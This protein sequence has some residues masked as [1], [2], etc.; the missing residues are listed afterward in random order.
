MDAWLAGAKDG[1]VRTRSGDR[2]KPSV[3][4]SHETSMRLRVLDELGALKLSDVTRP[5]LQ[6]VADRMLA[7]GLDPSTIRNALMPLRT[8]FRAPFLAA[9]SPSTDGGS[10]A[11]AVRGKRDRIASPAEAVA[12]L[13]A[14]PEQERALWAT[15]CYA[16]LR[17]GELRALRFEDVDLDAG[18]IRVERSWDPKEGVIEPKS[19]A[20]AADGPDRGRA[21]LA[22]RRA[23][24]AAVVA[25][26]SHLRTHRRRALQR[27]HSEQAGGEGV[28]E[29]RRRPHR[30]A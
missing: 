18:V 19:R 1:S 2:Y 3:L 5:Q 10:R 21:S 17:L 4:R 26:G 8:I 9:S 28:G 12:L 15:A 7:N 29:A 16:G 20:R 11:A 27:E 23:P 6:D 24:A 13:A 30:P 25:G 14:L 22:P